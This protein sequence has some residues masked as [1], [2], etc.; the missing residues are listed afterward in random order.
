MGCRAPP[1]RARAPILSLLRTVFS[2]SWSPPCLV[3]QR[4][5][6]IAEANAADGG[7]GLVLK[8]SPQ[9]QQVRRGRLLPD[10]QGSGLSGDTPKEFR[11]RVRARGWGERG[12]CSELRPEGPHFYM[13]AIRRGSAR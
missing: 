13:T 5:Q 1:H 10:F 4:I 9:E 12:N 6:N 11:A 8:G 3:P 2:G 7:G